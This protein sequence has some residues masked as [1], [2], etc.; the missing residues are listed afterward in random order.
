MDLITGKCIK[1]DVKKT[2]PQLDVMRASADAREASVSPR[3]SHQNESVSVHWNC[4]YALKLMLICSFLTVA[5]NLI[6]IN[7]FVMSENAGTIKALS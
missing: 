5:S 7:L 3:G 6:L 4:R 1:S 2:E